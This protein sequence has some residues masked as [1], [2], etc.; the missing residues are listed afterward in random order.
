M[1]DVKF[2]DLTQIIDAQS[3]DLVPI[4]D[5]SDTT[6]SESGSN[7]VISIG[8]LTSSFFT[9]FGDGSI[10]VSKL[11]ANPTFSGNVTLPQTTTI[12][13]ITPT[14]IGFL[15]GLRNN[16]QYQLDNPVFSSGTL[17]VGPSTGAF[18]PLK[19]APG[20]N[21][22]SPQVGAIE[23]DGTSLSYTNSSSVRQ[24]VAPLNSPT[25]TG[26]TTFE[27]GATITLPSNSVTSA[28]IVNG[29]IVD[30]DIS[31]TAAIA[32]TKINPSF[33]SQAIETTGTLTI[34]DTAQFTTRIGTTDVTPQSQALGNGGNAGALLG[35][36][37]ADGDSACLSFAKSRSITKGGHVIV[38]AGN[39]LGLL[40][41]GGSDGVKIVEAARILAE[42]DDGAV[43]NAG[44][45]VVGKRY[46]ISDVGTTTNWTAI[47]AASST[48]DTIFV[49]T[50]PGSGNGKATTEPN[51]DDMPGRLVFSTTPPGATT[52]TER[53]HINSAGNVGIN[54]A[55]VN[56][57]CLLQLHSTAKGFR[58]PAMTT[59]QRNA[60]SNPIA[61][62][63]IY[64]TITNKLNFYNGSQ[65]EAV[66]SAVGA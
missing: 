10:S 25:F 9:G 24:T 22:T 6:M 8:D 66:T 27:T 51:L 57:S 62:L 14:E 49:A 55:S 26:T 53:M 32:G 37:T 36:F 23:F 34:G 45:F 31:P 54:I 64:N 33:G 19:I 20:T 48:I 29:T 59:S 2:S 58:P 43:V 1:P 50:G 56:P 61:G 16:I 17:T 39:D 18:A 35:R 42:V 65:W 44:S 63:M 28:M 47:G 60:I 3:S 38:W 21:L 11:E 15:T 5:V 12:G 40:S 52:V 4:I 7:A 41:F 46:K 13:S 30:A